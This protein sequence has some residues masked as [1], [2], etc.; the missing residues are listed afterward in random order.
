[1]AD[2]SEFK[3]DQTEQ[4][5][6]TATEKETNGSKAGRTYSQIHVMIHAERKPQKYMV[7]IVFLVYLLVLA[8]FSCF[9]LGMK[10]SGGPNAG[11]HAK[12]VLMLSAD[13]QSQ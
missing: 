7:N 10:D 13:V 4:K 2:L 12:A 11:R 3:V 6:W 5:E 9:I 8:S 1:M